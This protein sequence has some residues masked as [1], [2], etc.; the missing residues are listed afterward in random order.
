[1]LLIHGL[2]EDAHSY[3]AFAESLGQRGFTVAAWDLRGH[4][5]STVRNGQPYN[6]RNFTERDVMAM[7]GDVALELGILEQGAP[8]CAAIV[9][10]S[11][12]AN[13]ALRAIAMDPN[14]SAAVLLSPGL[15]YHGLTTSD[16]IGQ[17]QD[18]RILL[19][20]ARQDSYA[21][22]SAAQLASGLSHAS[23]LQIEGSTH[24]TN[25]LRE[26]DLQPRLIAWLLE[27]A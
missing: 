23:F 17:V 7:A 27:Q 1:M 22:Q 11:I 6:L 12:G 15:D 24:G 4:G 2:N 18:R 14:V 5:Q 25:L 19:A 8:A 3:D 26:G 13:L 21:F 10:A 9:G 20:A 16:L